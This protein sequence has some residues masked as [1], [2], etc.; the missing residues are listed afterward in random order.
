[1]P[2]SCRG[3]AVLQVLLCCL[4]GPLGA[5]DMPKEDYY[6]YLPLEVPRLVRQ[7][8]ASARF[9]LYGDPADP[10]YR[11]ERPRNGIDDRRD[12]VLRW[13]AVRFAPFMVLNSTNIPMD[14]KVFARG[15]NVYRLHVDHWNTVAEGGTLAREETIDLLATATDP[16]TAFERRV[17]T[18]KDDCRLLELLDDYDPDQPTS[19]LARARA[20]EPDRDLFQ[21]LY[22]DFPGY[23]EP[24][25][26]A[27]FQDKTTGQ[28]PERYRDALYTY[29][30]PFIDAI[31]T[32]SGERGW[33]LVLQYWFF[34]P[35]NDGGNNHKGDWEH[36]NVVV[37]PRGA[38]G[39]LLT[40]DDI[41]S[42]LAGEAAQATGDDALVIKRLDYYFHHKVFM[43]DFSSPNVYLPREAWKRELEAKLE[44]RISQDWFWHQVR[45]RA[46]KDAEETEINTHP[47]VFIGADNK[48]FDQILA[49]PGGKNRDSHGSFPFPGLYK[50]IGPG[51]A[52]EEIST[53]FDH[54]KFFASTEEERTA[55][56]T[57][58][59][60][61]GVVWLADTA[62][63]GIVPDWERVRDLVRVDPVA[64]AQWGWLLL[65]IRF[66]YPASPSPFAGIVAH[67]ETGNISILGPGFSSGW[68]RAG[69]SAGFADYQPHKVPRLFPLGIQDGFQNSWGFFNVFAILGVL[70]PVDVAWR[71]VAAP[72]RAAL[73][74]QEPTF[75]PE[76][77]IPYRF[78]GL[79]SGVST[80]GIPDD[81]LDLMI[82]EQQFDEII[83]S[84]I[85]FQLTNGDTTSVL[86]DEQDFADAAT[87]P[88]FQ[89]AF[90]IGPRFVS[91]SMLRNSHSGVGLRLQ[92]SD[93]EEPYE[94]D[95][96][97]NL[98]EYAGSVRYNLAT[99]GLMPYAKVGYGLSW[100]RIQDITVYG[101]PLSTPQTK[102]TTKWTWHGGAGLELVTIRN[103]AAPPG[104]I[105]VSIRADWTMY[106]HRL[107]LDIGDLPLE[108]LVLLGR[109][110]SD[111]PRD[112]YVTR[113]E[114][115]LGLTLGF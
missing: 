80:Q 15:R 47:V 20:M 102:W 38:V 52:A 30:H 5:Q 27:E 10:G 82:N 111:L 17:R 115:R 98:W 104:G 29:V 14:F 7:T 92:W 40:E 101:E 106:W 70:P 83:L 24:S 51:G 84:I 53:Y 16:C 86:V 79:T 55:Q 18:A 11:D 12:D 41:R 76:A 110:A 75:Y 105:D 3:R 81:F 73:G 99:G 72:F 113:H 88:Y 36:L 90:F 59:K 68:N 95:G 54:Q 43:L 71:L 37:S 2:P 107:G 62:R 66:G 25:W 63:V 9:H 60:R 57:R 64:R 56:L 89:L 91:E 42:I 35:Y 58:W 33:E 4:G 32:P 28:L 8:A 49:M 45:S 19:A 87:A 100:Y 114:W 44:E 85:L 6:G 31:V 22:V 103:Y 1:M 74:R 69:A 77:N 39:R 46:Y 112:R 94:L 34:Y 50:D 67:A 93:I 108:T 109:G 65:P 61:G 97:L 21:V 48:G 26:R 78:F 96:R 23:D 13:M